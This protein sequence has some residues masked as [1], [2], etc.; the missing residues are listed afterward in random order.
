MSKN[1]FTVACKGYITLFLILFSLNS[2]SLGHEEDNQV[3]EAEQQLE[4]CENPAECRILFIRAEQKAEEFEQKA[5]EAGAQ[6]RNYEEHV[7]IYKELAEDYPYNRVYEESAKKFKPRAQES[8]WKA[9]VYRQQ[10]TRYRQIARRY[11][12][13]IKEYFQQSLRQ[14]IR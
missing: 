2:G 4:S 7:V 12:Q 6:A 13:Q 14:K 8:R 3:Y 9:E 10:A 5:K 1:Y 11:E